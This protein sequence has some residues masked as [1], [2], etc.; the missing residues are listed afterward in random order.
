MVADHTLE[1]AVV[2]MFKRNDT[3][4]LLFGNRDGHGVVEDHD[5]PNG[6][7]WEPY[8]WTSAITAVERLDA[9]T[10][11]LALADGSLE[12]FTYSNAGSI[13]IANLEDVRDL[14]L[15]PVSG[16]VYAAAGTSVQA[17]NP[18]NGQIASSYDIGAPVYYVLPLLNR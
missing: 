13:T 8:Q 17:I 7:G 11:L 12:R 16:W 2:A 3:H 18:Q 6:G 15:D 14:S 9:N 1:Q 5:I 4:V 10:H